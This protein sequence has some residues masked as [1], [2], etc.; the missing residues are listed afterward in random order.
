MTV[1][2][3]YDE[4]AMRNEELEIT[5]AEY[6]EETNQLNKQ[7]EKMKGLLNSLPDA[8]LAVNK[9]YHIVQINQPAAKLLNMSKESLIGKKYF[10]I[11]YGQDHPIE[12][13]PLVI[14]QKTLKPNSKEISIP[15]IRGT[16]VCSAALILDTQSK[17]KGYS[18]TLRD[19]TESKRRERQLEHDHKMEA[20]SILSRSVGHELNNLLMGIQGTVS[21]ALA[22]MDESLP[23]VQKMRRAEEFVGRG[24]ELTKQLL[25]FSTGGEY[26][27]KPVDVHTLV[28]KSLKI[29]GFARKDVSVFKRLQN[30]IWRIQVDEG[31]IE[32]VLLNLY[33]NACEAMPKGGELNIA[34]ENVVF[35]K[36]FAD[37]FGVG[38]GRYVKLS[39]TDT[40]VGMD[41][42]TQ[43]NIFEPF[44]TSKGKG[45]GL[46][47]VFSNRIVTNHQGIISVYSAKGHG[48]TFNIYLPAS[49]KSGEPIKKS[50]ES[51]QKGTGTILLVDDE[52]MVLEVGEEMLQEMGYN[53]LAASSG[54][55]ALGVYKQ[56]QD[57]IALVILDMIM[58]GMGG[59][60]VFDRIKAM[61]SDVKVLLASGYGVTT[62][63][64][65]ILD[66]GCCGF[67][68]KP[69]NMG[70]LSHKIK[71]VLD[72]K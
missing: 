1:M 28:E 51:V 55:E 49:Q 27:F 69:F 9:N 41:Q 16:F 14:A 56:N 6:L 47:L 25:G 40:G 19:V 53:V 11:I 68:Q 31:Q 20:I 44:F 13:C 24:K 65:D 26:E 10:N 8:V 45:I 37:F 5:V 3:S 4:L 35:D 15:N 43:D 48:T 60:E 34:A 66:R 36:D 59:S 61:N 17:L 50:K 18:L 70:R 29:F 54:R 7:K 67:M 64:T 52:K 57:K 22:E 21:L 72:E 33:S 2:L 32:Q 62:Q 71:N 39:I 46:G 42:V 30:N 12:E 38:E 63:I 58:P 23:V